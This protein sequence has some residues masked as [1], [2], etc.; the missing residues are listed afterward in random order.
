MIYYVFNSLDVCIIGQK[1]H[2]I[3]K[4]IESKK[5][6]GFLFYLIWTTDFL[7]SNKPFGLKQAGFFKRN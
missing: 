1:L 5:V 4:I 3:I 6:G 2:I 7:S